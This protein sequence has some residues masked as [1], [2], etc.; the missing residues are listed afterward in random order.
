MTDDS[1]SM[2]T[3]REQ[4]ASIG[5]GYRV[6]VFAGTKQQAR[7]EVIEDFGQDLETTET[8]TDTHSDPPRRWAIRTDDELLVFANTDDIEVLTSE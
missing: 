5:P 4:A 7:G 6:V 3:S 8:A 1:D 2:K